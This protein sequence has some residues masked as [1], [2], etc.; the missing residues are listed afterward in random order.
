MGSGMLPAGAYVTLEHEY[1]LIMRQG[2]KRN[3]NAKGKEKRQ[4][5]AIFWEE[6]NEWYADQWSQL[7]GTRQDPGDRKLKRRTAAYP[8]EVPWRLIHMY[9]VQEDVVLDPFCGT[10]TTALAALSSSRNS[11]QFDTDP[12][13]MKEALLTPSRRSTKE[14]LNEKIIGRLHDHMSYVAG[15][16]MLF[17]RYRNST[18]GIPV[19]TL[20][21]KLLDIPMIKSIRRRGERVTVTHRKVSREER[22]QATEHFMAMIKEENEE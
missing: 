4:A 21:E 20:Q 19:K 9:S 14:T 1:I 8:F 15:K 7:P 3:F 2:G 10:G 12:A 11:I 6:R 18:L 5:S 22:S 13:F 16:G 17:F